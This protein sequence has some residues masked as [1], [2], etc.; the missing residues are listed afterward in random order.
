MTETSMEPRIFVVIAAYNEAE[1]IRNVVAGVRLLYQH[2]V[3]VN[4]GSTDDTAA[5]LERSGAYV[6]HHFLNRGQGAALQTGIQFALLHGAD[7]IVT[8][9]ADGQHSPQD[10]RS[11][12][13][14]ILDGECDVVLGSR[15]LGNA[16]NM[17]FT[18]R[19]ILKL[20]IIFTRVVSGISVTDVHNGLRSF[21]RRAASAIHINLDRMAHAS[22]ILDQVKSGGWSYKEAPVTIIYSAYS[23][24][25]GQS[26]LGALQI[27]FDLL[28]GRLNR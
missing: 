6:L 14:P 1:T 18:R 19:L 8:F 24:A 22:D 26:S 3:V 5:R 11:L 12:V 15:F 2:V 20:G 17:P 13:Q 28:M 27:C 9:D 23:L 10:I 16:Q 25:K 7:V 4:D 21:S